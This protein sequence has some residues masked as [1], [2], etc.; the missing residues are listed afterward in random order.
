[1]NNLSI[2]DVVKTLEDLAVQSEGLTKPKD[3]LLSEEEINDILEDVIPSEMMAESSDDMDTQD[4]LE[5]VAI[6]NT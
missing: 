2:S 4:Y 6:I 3:I 1:M 5:Q